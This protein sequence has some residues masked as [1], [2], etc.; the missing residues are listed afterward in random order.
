VEL[1]RFL[2]EV[3]PLQMQFFPFDT[4]WTVTVDIDMDND[5]AAMYWND[6]LILEWQWSLKTD[7][8][9]GANQLGCVNMYAGALQGSGDT[10]MY[11][12]DNFGFYQMSTPLAPPTAEVDVEEIIVGISDGIAVTETFT[13]S[14][15]GEQDLNYEVYSV[16]D[17]EE[18]TGNAT[19]TIAHC[20]DFNGGV[21][22]TAATVVR[23]AVL[24][25]PSL[26]EE[27]IGTELTEIEFYMS[28]QALDF[29]VKVWAQG[30]TTVPG[31]G[32]EIYSA[33]FTPTIGAW[34]AAELDEPIILD[35]TPLWIGLAY[36][37]PAGLFS[38]GCDIGPKVPGVNFRSTGPAWGELGLDLNYNIR[39]IVTGDP[40]VP[41][42]SIPVD[43]GIV[44][45][46]GDET[47]GVFFDP[48]GLAIGQYTG[49]IVI[50]ANDPVTNYT[51][52]ATTLDIIT[53]TNDINETAALALY[54]NPTNDRVY[55]RADAN[56]KEVRIINY[57]GQT[58]QVYQMMETQSPIDLSSFD[59]GVYFFE[60]STEN[61]QH[62]VKVV[63]N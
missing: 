40:I 10:P 6:E 47:V 48:T 7:G 38:M 1:L 61:G 33:S 30:S 44:V 25:T 34:S 24:L 46:G 37:Q 45:A 36:F 55:L 32:D 31:P 57:L 21:G 2:Q 3:K 13:L 29:Q 20:G 17:I 60:V 41:Y 8:T 56:I 5:L 9:P 22:F 12:F 28:D 27:Y 50:A 59:S 14:N 42:M 15:V 43:A 19:A 11:Y 18:V 39:G 35:G 26:M 58:V 54:P 4:W 51:N 16:Y 23:N 53:S 52:I 62:T 63:K 49:Q